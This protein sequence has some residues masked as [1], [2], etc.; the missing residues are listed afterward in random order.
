MSLFE[1]NPPGINDLPKIGLTF[2]MRQDLDGVSHVGF[3]M[4]SGEELLLPLVV[5]DNLWLDSLFARIMQM[6][7]LFLGEKN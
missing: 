7:Q 1:A 2:Y 6:G 5:D 4:K 3:L